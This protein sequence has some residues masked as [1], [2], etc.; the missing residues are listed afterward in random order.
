MATRCRF[1]V[2]KKKSSNVW[3]MNVDISGS[4]S[5]RPRHQ[6]R[7]DSSDDSDTRIPFDRDSSTNEWTKNKFN[8]RSVWK[9]FDGTRTFLDGRVRPQFGIY[10]ISI[11]C[12]NTCARRIRV[13]SVGIRSSLRSIICRLCLSA[14]S[15]ETFGA[16]ANRSGS[17]REIF[18]SGSIRKRFKDFSSTIRGS[19]G[20][21]VLR[22]YVSV[23]CGGQRNIEN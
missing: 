14:N 1:S 5:S 21:T 22:L 15:S 9:I 18:S 16:F 6:H 2:A 11:A 7:L 20:R 10:F 3:R 23:F 12:G 4:I 19:S 17:E 13:H 8:V